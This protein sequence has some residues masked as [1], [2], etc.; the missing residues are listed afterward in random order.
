MSTKKA[1]EHELKARLHELEAE[2]ERFKAKTATAAADAKL[3]HQSELRKIEEH[4]EKMLA[5]LN[6]LIEASDSAWEDLKAGTEAAWEDL[7]RAVNDSAK[8]FR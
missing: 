2:I 7:K 4:R 6:K 1:Y 8:H 3:M 5:K